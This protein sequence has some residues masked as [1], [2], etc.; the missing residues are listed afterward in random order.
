MAGNRFAGVL[1]G[2][3]LA[4]GITAATAAMAGQDTDRAPADLIVG[5]WKSPVQEMWDLRFYRNGQV[6]EVD[7]SNEFPNEEKLKGKYAFSSAKNLLLKF[8]SKDQVIEVECE[9]EKQ[10]LLCQADE[11]QYEYTKQ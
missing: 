5:D 1:F 4:T 7:L 9:L 11:Y 6:E 3:S 8:N 10:V 2:V